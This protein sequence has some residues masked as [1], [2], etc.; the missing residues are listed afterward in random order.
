MVMTCKA[1]LRRIVAAERLACS[2]PRSTI[3]RSIST[4][5]PSTVAGPSTPSRVLTRSVSYRWIRSYITTHSSVPPST[6]PRTSTPFRR[7]AATL[8]QAV[9]PSHTTPQTP[10]DVIPP[11]LDAIKEEGYLDDDVA[12]IPPEEAWLNITPAA[13]SVSSNSVFGS[14]VAR[15]TT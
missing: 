9:E 10:I 2:S 3:A 1:C 13:V 12:L 6:I 11:S 5:R 8:A 7:T 15:L 4:S 14:A